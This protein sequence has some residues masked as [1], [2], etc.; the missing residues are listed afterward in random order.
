M[1]ILS[2][3]LINIPTI[4]GECSCFSDICSNELRTK[5]YTQTSGLFIK[6]ILNRTTTKR[7]INITEWYHDINVFI[8]EK[9][10]SFSVLG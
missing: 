4:L 9:I 7:E 3:I 8:S 6:L 1:E 2:I 10:V 5:V